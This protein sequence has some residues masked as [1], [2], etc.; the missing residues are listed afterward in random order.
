VNKTINPTLNLQVS[1][2]YIADDIHVWR[3]GTTWT[4]GLYDTDLY[5][6]RLT[7]TNNRH[8]M[9]LR[10]RNATIPTDAGISNAYLELCAGFDYTTVPFYARIVGDLESN[11]AT[12]STIANYQSRRGTSCGGSDDDLRTTAE[13]DWD[14]SET[15]TMDEW[16]ETPDIRT[17]VQEIVDQSGW[18]SGNAIALF[19]DDH[20]YRDTTSGRKRSCYAADA[21]DPAKLHIEYIRPG[22]DG[23]FQFTGGQQTQS[24]IQGI[25]GYLDSYNPTPVFG[26]TTFWVMLTQSGS[27]KY[28]QVGWLKG[29]GDSNEYIWLQYKDDAGVQHDKFYNVTN[30]NWYDVRQSVPSGSHLYTVTYDSGTQT[31]SM[32]YESGTTSTFTASWVPDIFQVYG[33]AYNYDSPNLGDHM[34]GDLNNK[35][36]AQQLQQKVSGIWGN[37][38]SS[39]FYTAGGN[40]DYDTSVTT[41]PGFR[42]WDTRCNN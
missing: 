2:N 39:D 1:I 38:S 3:T 15:W 36:Q 30:N 24:N 11:A 27:G 10:F 20:D 25:R 35:I 17:V 18:S 41:S 12:F 5:I 16:Y 32:Q 31:F 29:S 22:T 7:S 40:G 6:G 14:S 13:V 33:E 21:A 8:G 26:Q 4:A 19:C 42:I 37:V 9:G 34:P 28:A 23:N